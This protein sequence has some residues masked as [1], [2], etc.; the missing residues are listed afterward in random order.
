MS[1]IN[2][3]YIDVDYLEMRTLS[4]TTKKYKTNSKDK[5][6]ICSLNVEQR[7]RTAIGTLLAEQ[8]IDLNL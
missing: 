8:T 6:D 2:R 4:M 1:S 3:S 7:L 5:I